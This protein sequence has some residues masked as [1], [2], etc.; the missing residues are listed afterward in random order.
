[1]E[2]INRDLLGSMVTQ[3]AN[4]EGIARACLSFYT[5]NMMNLGSVQG[6]LARHFVLLKGLG[7]MS[8]RNGKWMALE[9][10]LISAL[11]LISVMRGRG[12][13]GIICNMAT[14]C[15]SPLGQGSWVC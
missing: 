11:S 8:R 1:M 2:K 13:L 5:S 15:Q 12:I 3:T 9:R 14:Q 4:S 10:Q 6:I 7:V